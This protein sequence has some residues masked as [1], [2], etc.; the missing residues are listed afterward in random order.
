MS[1]TITR[2][3]Q[4]LTTALTASQPTLLV[5]SPGLGKSDIVKS[6]ARER[7]ISLIDLRL[8]QLSEVDLRGVPSTEYGRTHWN[9]PDFFPTSGEGILFLDELTSATPSV[10]VS[11]YQLILD[12]RLGDY[13]LPDGWNIIAAGNKQSDGAVVYRMSSALKNRFLILEVVSDLDGWL[14]WARATGIAPEIIGFI[15]YRPELLNIFET[16]KFDANV[17]S[18]PTQRSWAA[19]SK[20][21]K[22][23]APMADLRDFATGLVGEGAATELLSFLTVYSKLPAYAAIKADPK[24]VKFS[25]NAASLYAITAMVQSYLTLKD[26]ATV[27]PFVERLNKEFQ[28]ILMRGLTE[29]DTLF[30][31]TPEFADWAVKNTAVLF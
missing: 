12:R 13:V 4:L 26:M 24:G 18:F 3:K 8:S 21:V 15:T 14:R 7:G 17:M 20:F 5:G 31:T 10:Q 28:V 6:I 22:A 1:V 9:T 29:R 19:L 27:Y 16:D 2:A 30:S 25:N 11:A 23:G